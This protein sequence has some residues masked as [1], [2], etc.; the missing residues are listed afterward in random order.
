M[1]DLAVIIVSTNDREWLTPCLRSVYE[2]AGDLDIDV[3]VADNESTDGTRELIRDEFPAARVVTSRNR[4]FGHANNRAA[5]T[6]NARYLLFL[7]PDTEI[8][9]GTLEQLVRT[10]DRRP[11]I[12]LAGVRQ[13]TADG[14]VY[15]TM[16][17]FPNALRALG[18]ALGSERF[19]WSPDC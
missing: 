1:H 18:E 9:D 17:R 13:L 15:P 10:L 2:R 4:G 16:R 19:P 8:L 7:N 6:C 14:T 5:M 12:G 11:E 3:V